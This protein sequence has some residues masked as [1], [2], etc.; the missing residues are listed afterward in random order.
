MIQC[1][2]IEY[3][4]VQTFANYVF[5]DAEHSPIGNFIHVQHMNRDFLWNRLAQ[6]TQP[7]RAFIVH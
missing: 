7:Q 5:S 2:L 1:Q 6:L 4:T 3:D